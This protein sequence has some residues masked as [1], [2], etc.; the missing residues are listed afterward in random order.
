MSGKHKVDVET[1]EAH[2]T[3]VILPMGLRLDRIHLSGVGLSILAKPF[4]AKVQRP[5][6]LEVVITDIDVAKFLDQEAP[7]GLKNFQVE[8]VAGKLI[9]SAVKNMI[10][11]VKARAICTLRVMGGTQLFVDLE[12]ADVMGAGNI[13]GLL[14]KQLEELNP[15][16]DTADLPLNARITTVEAE[17]GRILLRGEVA[18]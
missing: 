14:E 4:E 5:G 17:A 1:Y 8:I 15:V 16:F 18:P 3:G 10:I 2:L 13:K 12:A 7:A 6:R 11:D 9:V